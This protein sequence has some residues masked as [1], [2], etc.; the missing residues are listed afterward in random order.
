MTALPHCDLSA[1]GWED[2]CRE[3]GGWEYI[4]GRIGLPPHDQPDDARAVNE[5]GEKVGLA[6]LKEA[7]EA[8]EWESGGG[9]SGQDSQDLDTLGEAADS[10]IETQE[11]TGKDEDFAT[12]RKRLMEDGQVEAEAD[13]PD[14][15]GVQMLEHMMQKMQAVR[16]MGADLPE[17]ERKKFAAKAMSEVIRS[18]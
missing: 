5:Y 14:E 7:L 12:L 16:D 10:D 11:I 2:L 6:R 9:G 8:N 18:V 1:E 15:E 3:E 17:L 4:D 13:E